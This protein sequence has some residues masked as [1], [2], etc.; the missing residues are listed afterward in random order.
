VAGRAQRASGGAL[1]SG[2]LARQSDGR[3]GSEPV[4]DNRVIPPVSVTRAGLA[5]FFDVSHFA[6]RRHLTVPADDA[7]ATEGGETEKPNETHDALRPERQQ[8]LCRASRLRKARAKC[9]FARTDIPD[10]RQPDSDL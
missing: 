6:A 9:R 1:G 8:Y 7:A 2:G 4:G 3:T 5:L 10:Y